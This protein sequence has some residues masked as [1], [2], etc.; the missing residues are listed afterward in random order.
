M[1]QRPRGQKLG[2]PCPGC[3]GTGRVLGQTGN[4]L[5]VDCNQVFREATFQAHGADAMAA[6]ATIVTEHI[7]ASSRV[8]VTQNVV[9]ALFV[10]MAG[11][12]VLFAPSGRELAAEVIGVAFLVFGA[13][14]AGFANFHVRTPHVEV[15]ASEGPL[16]TTRQRSKSGATDKLPP[17][18]S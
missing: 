3:G 13:G 1:A 12:C 15:S 4:L 5:C 8:K 11:L 17:Q 2:S 6:Q 18:S 16:P 10:I 14:I 7:R 9:A